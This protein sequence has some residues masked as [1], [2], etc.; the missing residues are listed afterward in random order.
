MSPDDI[1]VWTLM[2]R[3]A[4]FTI[5]TGRIATKGAKGRPAPPREDV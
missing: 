2:D 3:I 1:R 5:Y 4:M